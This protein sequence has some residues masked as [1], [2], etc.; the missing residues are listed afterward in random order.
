MRSWSLLYETA[1]VLLSFFFSFQFL[2]LSFLNFCV[3]FYLPDLPVGIVCTAVVADNV[4]SVGR[5]TG[6][7]GK[8][9]TVDVVVKSQHSLSG[10]SLQ[11]TNCKAP[12]IM[13]NHRLRQQEERIFK[14]FILKRVM[15]M[16]IKL[17][18]L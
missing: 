11:R 4:L 5:T 6:G 17:P 13:A 16:T 9:L 3:F 10:N 18:L 7:T 15:L 8:G 12:N 1:F 14:F 2:C